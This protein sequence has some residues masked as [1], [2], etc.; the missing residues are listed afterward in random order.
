M[1]VL[2]VS[3]SD[4]KSGRPKRDADLLARFR[5]EHIGEPCED[6]ELRP[7]I[8]VHHRKFRSKLGSDEDSNLAWLCGPCH[9][10][11]HGVRSS[12]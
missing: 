10:A 11:A 1:L 4:W 7:G 6:C 8:H 12:W 2:P 3:A 5:L 9:D